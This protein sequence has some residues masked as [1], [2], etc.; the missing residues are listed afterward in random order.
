[1]TDLFK[2]LLVVGL[3][4][5]AACDRPGHRGDQ[6]VDLAQIAIRPTVTLRTD[7]VG[8]DQWETRATFVLVDADNRGDQPLRVTLGGVLVDDDG[9]EVGRVKAE[10]LTIPARGRRTFALVDDRQAERPTAVGANIDVRGARLPS[11]VDP[12][13][14][15]QGHAW[16]DHGKV[17]VTGMVVNQ[18]DSA[19]IAVVLAGFH[20]PDGVPMTR[21]FAV[22][23]LGGKAEK[24]TRFVGPEGS[25]AGYIF[26][27]DIRC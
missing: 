25:K 8:H 11:G 1:M 3:A 24:P 27:G 21:P 16:N 4:L 26:V 12:V 14:V 13:G 7:T 17:V 2:S 15:T 19:C 20:G 18:S 9:R 10:T 23:E 5:G 6:R 22:F